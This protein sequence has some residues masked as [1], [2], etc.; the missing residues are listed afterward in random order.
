[1]TFRE[2]SRTVISRNCR[3]FL[4]DFFLLRN[5]GDGGGTGTI[6]SVRGEKDFSALIGTI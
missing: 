5:K 6:N 1:M 3:Q 2:H 4:V